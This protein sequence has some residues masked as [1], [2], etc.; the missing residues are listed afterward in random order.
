MVMRGDVRRENREISAEKSSMLVIDCFNSILN[1]TVEDLNFD[2]Q[3]I[4]VKIGLISNFS[5]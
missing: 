3:L 5:S 2:F 4:L 1:A